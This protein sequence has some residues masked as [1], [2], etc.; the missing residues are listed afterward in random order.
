MAIVS[1]PPPGSSEPKRRE[2]AYP[3][4]R[5]WLAGVV[6]DHLAGVP[7]DVASSY[8]AAFRPFAAFTVRQRIAADSYLSLTEDHGPAALLPLAE[9]TPDT[10]FRRRVVVSVDG[11]GPFLRTEDGEIVRDRWI[12]AALFR[13]AP[14]GRKRHEPWT[15][16][17]ALLFA[18]LQPTLGAR[19]AARRLLV[20][21]EELGAPW[22]IPGA[23]L[24]ARFDAGG[25]LGAQERR[26]LRV[27]EQAMIRSCGRAGLAAWLTA[28]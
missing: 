9:E 2:Y 22:R 13:H 5:A 24:A 6:A 23:G 15:I 26:T 12:A 27:A 21:E 14:G 1:K 19:P 25:K 3:E 8:V 4:R 28:P 20:W 16:A 7:L 10:D 18:D 17:R 11:G